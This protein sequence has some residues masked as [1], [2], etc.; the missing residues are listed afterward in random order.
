MYCR[1]R[2]FIQDPCVSGDGVK[3]VL[4]SGVLVACIGL[5]LPPPAVAEPVHENLSVRRYP[6]S[7]AEGGSLAQALARATPIRPRW[8]QRFHGLTAWNITWRYQ[9]QEG[10]DGSCRAAD[11]RV[12]LVTEIT[13]PELVDAGAADRKAFDTYLEAL[14]V[15]ELGHH[16]IA[17]AA[18]GKVL[19]G[20][21]G[22]GV[23]PD[24]N[25]LDAHIAR[26]TDR[27]ISAAKSA[28]QRYDSETRFGKTQGVV[29]DP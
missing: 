12:E 20:I 4:L 27:L 9:Q 14:Q 28:E 17:R 7:V 11:P 6:V 29:L 8:W 26:L 16:D 24:C 23:L 19:S 2:D 15:H 5:G 25:A 18:A 1:S 3:R 21:E 22:A 10:A 13:L